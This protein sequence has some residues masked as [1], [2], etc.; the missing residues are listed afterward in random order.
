MKRKNQEISD[1]ACQYVIDH[2]KALIDQFAGKAES[3]PESLETIAYFMSRSP[4]AG[5]TEFSKNLIEF[6]VKVYPELKNQ[7]VRIDADEI[8][9]LLPS[10]IYNGQN[11]SEVQK[12]ASKGVD[13][14]FDHV[15]HKN[16]HFILDGTFVNLHY[17]R[18]NIKRAIKAEKI[19]KIWYVYQEPGVAWDFTR[20]REA[21]EGRKI[22][23]KDFIK[24][25]L[26]AKK[27]ANLIK[28]EF[29]ERIS[30][31]L[32]IKNRDNI[33]LETTEKN[34]EKID[35]YLIKPYNKKALEKLL[36]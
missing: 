33:G 5:K 19:I 2:K 29:G 30:L 31:N 28:K 9:E 25:F 36:S 34:M 4:G 6:M 3:F 16:K 13:K 22:T 24:A 21:L 10:D 7:I 23:K 26:N 20:K 32:V 27:N 14:L 11:A 35:H 8:R 12:A 18:T 1:L 15:I 17:A